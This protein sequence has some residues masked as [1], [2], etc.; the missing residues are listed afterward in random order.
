MAV[1]AATI[2]T[3]PTSAPATTSNSSSNSSSGSS[4]SGATLADNFQSFLMLLT[5]QLQNQNPLDPLDTNQFT[6]QLVQFAQVEQQ[7]KSNSQ[8]ESLVKI[9]QTAQSTQALVFVGQTVAVDGSTAHFDGNATWNFSAPSNSN[10]TVTIT[11]SAGQTAYSG[12]FA[13]GSGNSSFVWDGK[14]NDG[15]Q[16]PV[17]DY[18]MTVTA[19]DT[20]GKDI[21]IST[22]VQGTVDSV[23]LTASPA[24]LSIG[25]KN[26]TLDQIKRVVKAASS[27]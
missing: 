5:T 16:W 12:N 20:N 26:Y 22:E 23:D 7:L 17:G 9:E 10:A 14:G 18:K 1:D 11:N 27:A 4:T 13:I 6:Q 3:T 21:A 2:A 8:L 19:K 24:L 15:T 25:G